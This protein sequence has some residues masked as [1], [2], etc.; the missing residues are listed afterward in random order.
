MAVVWKLC[1]RAVSV[2]CVSGNV[3][4]GIFLDLV[5]ADPRAPRV[6]RGPYGHDGDA[7]RGSQLQAGAAT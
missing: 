3:H 5:L 1:A 2:G 6:E 7:E 4:Y